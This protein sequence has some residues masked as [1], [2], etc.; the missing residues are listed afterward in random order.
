MI[1]LLI[2]IFPFLNNDN[3]YMKDTLKYKLIG[4]SWLIISIDYGEFPA[5]I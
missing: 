3:R 5:N 2:C 4:V 1:T